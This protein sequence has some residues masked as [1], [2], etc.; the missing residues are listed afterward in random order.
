MLCLNVDTHVCANEDILCSQ[1]LHWFLPY[2]LETGLLLRLELT[3]FHP[4]QRPAS[5]SYLPVSVAHAQGNSWI[6]HEVWGSGFK[7]SCVYN[8]HLYPVIHL[9]SSVFRRPFIVKFEYSV[10][11][12][13]HLSPRMLSQIQQVPTVSW[14]CLIIYEPFIGLHRAASSWVPMSQDCHFFLLMDHIFS[15]DSLSEY[16]SHPALSSL[17]LQLCKYQSQC[18][19]VLLMALPGISHFEMTTSK[20]FLCLCLLQE[21]S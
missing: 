20:T 4:D 2:S 14:L 21:A 1:V 15:L 3:V 17:I 8:K 19:L 11:Q 13:V 6:S 5:L 9:P 7:S 12:K 10:V 16:G 18:A